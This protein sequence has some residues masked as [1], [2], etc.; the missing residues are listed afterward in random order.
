MFT[1]QSNDIFAWTI[2]KCQLEKNGKKFYLF[3]L[4]VIHDNKICKLTDQQE[5]KRLGASE[6]KQ[7][8]NRKNKCHCYCSAR[9]SCVAAFIWVRLAACPIVNGTY[10][11]PCDRVPN[12][13]VFVQIPI[14]IDFICIRLYSRAIAFHKCN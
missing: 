4:N 5:R 8:V 9:S 12:R 1:I 14:L 3:R 7:G 11:N 6:H 10:R 13:T 2:I